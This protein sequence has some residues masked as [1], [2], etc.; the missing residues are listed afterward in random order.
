MSVGCSVKSVSQSLLGPP[1]ERSRQTR[2]SLTAGP[3]ALP[4]TFL[5]YLV[6]VD[7]TRRSLQI[8]CTRFSPT[9]WPRSLS[10]SA[11][12]DARKAG[13]RRAGRT[14]RSRDEHCPSH[15]SRTARPT[16]RVTTGG[17]SP[18]PRRSAR[19]GNPRRP[20]LGPEGT[21]TAR[22]SSGRSTPKDL[23]LHLEPPILTPEPDVLLL[24]ARRQT[25]FQ[26]VIDVGVV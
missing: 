24:F 19:Q 25:I 22:R 7:Q 6:V 23:V 1:A 5:A 4:A 3:G 18:E 11:R 15:A 13:R 10:S 12:T 26:A 14:A 9:A 8:R 21:S 20:N 17:R 2:S 16:T